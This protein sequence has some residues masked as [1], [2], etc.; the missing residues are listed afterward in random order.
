[1]YQVNEERCKPPKSDA[2]IQR[3]AHSIAKHE[4]GI[5]RRIKETPLLGGVP[6][7][8]IAAAQT[9]TA[10]VPVDPKDWRK[11]FKKVSE[12]PEG[13]VPWLIKGLLPEGTIF[14]GALS[15][16]GKTLL[17]LSLARA[18]TTGRPMF[19][20]FEVPEQIPVLY[21]IPESSGRAFKNR[22]LKFRIPDDENKFL[23]RTLSDGPTLLLDD[24]YIRE[25][26]K[27][28]KPV[29]VLDTAIR[30]SQAKDENDAIQNQR[31]CNDIIALRVAGARS[32]VGVHH[33][34]K[35]SAK[36][37]MTLE[38]ILRGTGDLGAMAD[39][40]YGLRRDEVLYDEGRGPLEMNAKCVKP[41][42]FDPPLP[43]RLAAKYKAGDGS[44]RSHIDEIGDFAVV[45]KQAEQLNL[46]SQ[47]SVLITSDPEITIRELSAALH[48]NTSQVYRALQDIGW[49]KPR[50]KKTW[51]IRS[52]S[53]G[54]RDSTQIE[55]EQ[56]EP[57]DL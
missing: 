55:D 44:I 31:L 27:D 7:G 41:R 20:Q 40:V 9:K 29:V 25:A 50:G 15:G 48:V 47:L 57:V 16:H 6:A 52:K 36:E 17:G 37:E 24:P 22:V 34:T 23:C 26:V 38:N 19:G 18:L 30:F 28:L 54:G 35:A 49:N 5:D 8:T 13:D 21:L 11:Q 3:I 12:L 42:D 1:M 10:S 2:D 45:D 43:F 32:V 14:F 56:E 39:A 46:N 33:S 53:P 51:E 4:D